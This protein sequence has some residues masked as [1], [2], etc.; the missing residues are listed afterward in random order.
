MFFAIKIL[1]SRYSFNQPEIN[2]D[3]DNDHFLNIE[4][5]IVEE[6]P[7]VAKPRDS[8][9]HILFNILI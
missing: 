1:D 9:F 6:I 7:I 5:L 2:G 4:Y 3:S 8:P